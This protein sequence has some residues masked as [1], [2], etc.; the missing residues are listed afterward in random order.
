MEHEG[1]DGGSYLNH[2]QEGVRIILKKLPKSS[3][4]HPTVPETKTCEHKK[5]N[6]KINKFASLK[7]KMPL[8]PLHT[9]NYRIS[10]CH[11]E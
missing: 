6:Q 2:S 7:M 5:N 3:G 9:E 8:Y 10:A 11:K 1:K 4:L